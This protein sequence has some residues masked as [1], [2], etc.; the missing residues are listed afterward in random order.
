MIP[1]KI[2]LLLAVAA[3]SHTGFAHPRSLDLGSLPDLMNFEDRY[4]ALEE[5]HVESDERNPIETPYRLPENVIPFHY[6]VQLESS[7]HAG[8][9]AFKGKVDLYFNVSSPT[10]R[11]YVHN[12]GLELEKA[13]LYIYGA[14]AEPEKILLDWPRYEF[15]YRRE[16][17]IFSSRINLIPGVSY[18]LCLEF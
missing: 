3:S 2:I 13:E 4:K 9:R 5:S 18:I 15:D 11:V 10:R 1:L 12:R 16:F 17:I 6:W 7:I 8:D 14:G